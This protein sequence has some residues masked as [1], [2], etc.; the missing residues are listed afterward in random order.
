MLRL[1]V[2]HRDERRV[3]ETVTDQ[4]ALRLGDERPRADRIHHDRNP[5]LARERDLAEKRLCRAVEEN[6]AAAQDEQIQS[7]QLL[8]R[9]VAREVADADGAVDGVPLQGVVGVQALDGELDVAFAPER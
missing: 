1:P 3:G 5:Q 6:A 7:P 2:T 9:L 8:A 4:L